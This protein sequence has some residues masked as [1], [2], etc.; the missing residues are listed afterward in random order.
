MAR[1]GRGVGGPGEVGEGVLGR[2]RGLARERE[3][4]LDARLVGR[5]HERAAASLG[6]RE[7]DLGARARDVAAPAAPV[8]KGPGDGVVRRVGLPD[9]G[10][11]VRVVGPRAVAERVALVAQVV[12]LLPREHDVP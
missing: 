3:R 5:A 6:V 2:V 7:R 9:L 12:G 11:G 10:L 8:L 4:D 1:L